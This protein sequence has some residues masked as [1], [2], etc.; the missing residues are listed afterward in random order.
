MKIKFLLP[1]VLLYSSIAMGGWAQDPQDNGEPSGAQRLTQSPLPNMHNAA[2]DRNEDTELG[3]VDQPFLHNQDYIPNNV[4]QDLLERE[5]NTRYMETIALVIQGTISVGLSIYLAS[6]MAPEYLGTLRDFFAYGTVATS[7]SMSARWYNWVNYVK[8]FKDTPIPGQQDPFNLKKL[9]I[10][11]N[12]SQL[13]FYLVPA[14]I[15][16][17]KISQSFFS[18]VLAMTGA[19][20]VW[21][22]FN[23]G[24]YL[25]E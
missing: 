22:F 14:S 7:I 19:L 3:D 21:T 15:T 10:F 16:S 12:I 24:S 13:F 25:N 11:S 2:Q 23:I 9:D 20:S 17:H 1:F 8:P 4:I 18:G 5:A 6:E